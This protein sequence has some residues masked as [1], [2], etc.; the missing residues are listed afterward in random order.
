MEL[1]KELSGHSGSK[2]FLMKDN[3]LT[4]IRKVYNID[5][6][7]ER[8]EY[9]Y[10]LNLNVPKIYNKTKD[11]LDM[12]YINGLDMKTYLTLYGIDNF[13]KFI[14]QLL[15]TFSSNYVL[16]NYTDT[17]NL[18]LNWLADNNE[19]PFSKEQLIDRLPKEL[20]SS[21]YHGDLTLENVLY[22]TATNK[23]YLIDCLQSE[24][25]SWVFDICKLRQDLKCNWF[26]RNNIS[27]N[28]VQYTK[29]IDDLLIKKYDYVNNNNLLILMLLRVYPYTKV[30]SMDRL[31]ILNEVKKLWE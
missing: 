12:E 28:L 20:P 22:S 31:F 30:D 29:I 4:F 11:I 15:D 8:Q 17:Y 5:R 27:N 24:Y 19:F 18:K 2:I 9:L 13:I 16:K 6:N 14:T 23:F 21:I 7:Y 26:M 1:I 3:S 25:D 10:N